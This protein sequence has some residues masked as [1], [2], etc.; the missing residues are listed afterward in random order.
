[1]VPSVEFQ[2]FVRFTPTSILDNNRRRCAQAISPHRYFDII[3]EHLSVD[4]DKSQ[5]SVIG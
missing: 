2:I 5:V 1:M 4:E 3:G